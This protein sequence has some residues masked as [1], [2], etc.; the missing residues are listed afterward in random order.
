MTALMEL[1]KGNTVSVEGKAGEPSCR[2]KL[3]DSIPF[4][5]KFAIEEIESGSSVMKY[6]EVIGKATTKIHPGDWVH[7]HNIESTRGRGDL[8]ES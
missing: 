4:G 7:V 6:G 5:H 8:G 1:S 2:V 3:R